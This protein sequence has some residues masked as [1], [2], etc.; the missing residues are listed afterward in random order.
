MTLSFSLLRNQA[1]PSFTL[2]KN[3]RIWDVRT[4][5]LLRLWSTL[6]EHNPPTSGLTIVGFKQAKKREAQGQSVTLFQSGRQIGRVPLKGQKTEVLP[7]QLGHITVRI[8]NGRAWISESSC[9]HQICKL[10]PPV[11][12]TRERIICAPNHFLL[13]V[14]GDGS[15]DTVIG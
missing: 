13:E 12:L 3:G 11:S 14:Q 9:R 6:N 8:E 2:I 4:Q 10:S 5:K 1:R 7:G 15:I